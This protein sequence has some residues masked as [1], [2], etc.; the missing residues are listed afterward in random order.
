LR[1]WPAPGQWTYEDY[2]DLPDDGYRYEIIC[3]ELYMSPAPNIGH[4]KSSGELEYALQGFVRTHN[5]G[6]VLHAPC[7]VILAAKA[8]P[9]QPDILFV[10]GDRLH[11]ITEQNVYGAPDLII[12]ILSPT[13]RDYDRQQKFHLYEQVGV[14]E[15]WLVD[16]QER[17][18]EVFELVGGAY[19]LLGKWEEGQ[20]AMSHVLAGFEVAVNEVLG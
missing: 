11:I 2:R 14:V 17:I 13:T 9:V 5:L 8:T 6:I 20:R 10:S 4:Q 18:I 16:P 12:E 7:D 15:Y 3:G 19:I 1:Q